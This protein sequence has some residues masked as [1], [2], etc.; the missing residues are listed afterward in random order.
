MTT[1]A[2]LSRRLRRLSAA[3]FALAVIVTLI[4]TLHGRSLE[5]GLFMDDHAHARQLRESGWSLRELVDACRLDLF[6]KILEV[7]WQRDFSI[8]FFRPVAFACMKVVY[9]L[10]GWSA[11]AQH[12]ASLVWHATAVLLLMRLLRRLGYGY[13]A[14]LSAA[15]LFAIHP[16]QIATVQWIA[17]QS[18]L[19]VST[20]LL[21]A[22]HCF[23]NF[24][25]WPGRRWSDA[26]DRADARPAPPPHWGWLAATAAL[27]G[28]ALGCRENAIMLPFVLL[29]VE[30]VC[31]NRFRP[32]N[33]L[34]YGLLAAVALGYVA[35]RSAYLGG[36]ALPGR[37]Y[38]VPPTEPDFVPY[39]F[40]K[41]CYYLL[42]EFVCAPLVPITGLNYC[43]ENAW[44][45][46]PATGIIA[47]LMLWIALRARPRVGAVLGPAWVSLF[48][49]PVLPA[50]ESPH[51]LYLPGLGW[52]IVFAQLV[53]LA[54]HG[55][56]ALRGA[57]PGRPPGTVRV[58]IVTLV[59]AAL[60]VGFGAGTHFFSLTVDTAQDVEDRVADEVVAV[61]SELHD[62]DTLYFA[63][64]PLIAHYV[65]LI[66]E[67]RTGL[68]NLHAVALT[69]SPRLLGMQTPAELRWVDERTIDVEIASDR[70]FD[71]AF[72]KMV[73][74]ATHRPIPIDRGKPIVHG[75]LTVELLDA[76]PDAVRALRFRFDRPPGESG[77]H[78]F[79]GSRTRWAYHIRR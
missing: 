69:W 15:A 56:N 62:G 31:T 43:R 47:V 13:L 20:L 36:A 68:K 38:V 42:G 60:G 1:N 10:S 28:L 72:G 12:V 79:W 70:Y 22:V 59:V 3:A 39:V 51:H 45:F 77:V 64:L 54:A 2:P 7:W 33:L 71:G 24:R 66:V 18:E 46:Y 27:Y 41:F 74:D 19:I 8:R 37:P 61:A 4:A 5:Y 16:G 76:D 49:L 29:A 44:L 73:R 48:M 55:R 6:G 30:T 23:A 32:R 40:D 11:V 25:G 50:F 57:A 78:L 9:V 17:S 21:A 67:D 75:G 34:A 26:A 58:A 65:R 35:V 53:T 63:N 14:S 52:A